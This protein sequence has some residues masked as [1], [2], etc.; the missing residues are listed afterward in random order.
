MRFYAKPADQKWQRVLCLRFRY[1]PSVWSPRALVAF[2]T[3]HRSFIQP[4][5]ESPAVVCPVGRF[6]QQA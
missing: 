3:C 6:E 2:L 4:Q 5:L 1:K